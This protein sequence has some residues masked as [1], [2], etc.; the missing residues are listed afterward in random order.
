[1]AVVTRPKLS[2][3][4]HGQRSV[5]RPTHPRPG[6]VARPPPAPPLQRRLTPLDAAFYALESTRAPMHLGWAAVFNPPAEGPR[7][8]FEAIS[9]HIQGRLGRAPRYRQ[10]LVG[11]RSGWPSRCGPTTGLSRSPITSAAPPA[12][13]LAPWSTA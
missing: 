4:S 13:T 10:R 12:P 3:G 2:L 5:R 7:P 9:A 1:M 8:G 11:S 6:T